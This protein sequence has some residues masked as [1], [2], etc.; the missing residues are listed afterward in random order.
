MGVGWD[1]VEKDELRE[2]GR[3][4]PHYCTSAFLDV[5]SLC[6]SKTKQNKTKTCLRSCM[7]Y[8]KIPEYEEV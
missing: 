2:A 3:S 7:F 4:Y 8:S 6:C 5:A 1:E